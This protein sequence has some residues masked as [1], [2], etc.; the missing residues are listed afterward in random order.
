MTLELEIQS[1]GD[2]PA[3]IAD[4]LH[5]RGTYRLDRLSLADSR[6][7][8]EVVKTLSVAPTSRVGS[9]QGSF[10]LA[11]RRGHHGRL[12]PE[13]R[14]HPRWSSPAGRTP[15][16][17][18][19]TGCRCGKLAKKV[20]EIA[21]R[22]PTEARELLADLPIDDLPAM[23]EVRVSGTLDAPIVESIDRPDRPQA[24]VEGPARHPD[25]KARLKSAGRKLL[26]RVMR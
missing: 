3:Q 5:G 13:G 18:W 9:L 21:T 26:D 15:T 23:A 8:D 19:I 16:G 17:V 24:S 1:K 6:V 22:L 14:G 25:E 7:I 20:A 4:R 12:G 10:T 2:T 11:N